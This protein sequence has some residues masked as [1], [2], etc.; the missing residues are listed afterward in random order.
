[1]RGRSPEYTNMNKP[2]HD[3]NAEKTTTDSGLL[4]MAGE[5]T[6]HLRGVLKHLPSFVQPSFDNGLGGQ[7]HAQL[8]NEPVSKQEMAYIAIPEGTA[9]LTGDN[10]VEEAPL[11]LIDSLLKEQ[12]ELTAVERFAQVHA[13]HET[14]IGEKYYRDLVPT[15]L[16]GEGEQFAF[17]VDLDSCSGC[18]ACVAACHNLNGLEEDE[19]WRNVGQLVGGTTKLPVIQHVTTACHHCVE[20][21][22]LKGCP[23]EAYEKDPITGIVRH[24]DDQCI[25]CQ[26]CTLQCPYDV[27]VYSRSKGIVRKCDMCHQRLSAGE[28]PVCVQSC[29]NGA[30]RI[31][32]VDQQTIR[33]EC[34]VDPF[35]PGAPDPG[36]TLPTTHYKTDRNW[37]R[38]VLPA[39]YFHVQ[40]AHGHLP[41]VIML[42]LT[43]MSV[44][45]FIVE[46]ALHSFLGM[47]SETTADAVRPIHLGAALALGMLGLSAAIFHLGRPFYAYRALLGLRTSWLS[48]EILAFNVF[49]GVAT[50]YVAS[51]SLGLLA[52]PVPIPW[53]NAAGA[54]AALSGI[55]AVMCSVMIYVD[56]RRPLWTLERTTSIFLLTCLVLGLPTSL[57][58]SF[59]AAA[60]SS[61]LNIETVMTEY[62]TTLCKSLIVATSI[63]LLLEARIFLHLRDWQYTFR[64]RTALL[65]W[66]ELRRT[67]LQRFGF[68]LMGG[69]GVPVALMAISESGFYQNQL[70]VAG[71]ILSVGLLIAGELL[72]RYLFFVASVVPKMPGGPVR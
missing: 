30:I 31:R 32:I 49:A 3:N 25:G 37:P 27:P 26:Y 15:G 33:E 28:A 12:N 35:L 11:G 68:G 29:P 48:R 46:Y 23:V 17:E 54:A 22:C 19:L 55:A 45:A 18:Q 58:V 40:Q 69:I 59:I 51:A 4:G 14:P 6:R 65:M 9:M 52:H 5:F 47:L 63:K 62:G 60:F 34:E 7:V 24:L 41:L 21:A 56:C 36:N 64:R 38:N 8:T 53:Q 43:Q 10:A 72:E 57:L 13:D 66:H 20:P 61:S 16:P 2:V 70:L 50:L 71:A 42:V 39:D 67:T 1:M 44:G